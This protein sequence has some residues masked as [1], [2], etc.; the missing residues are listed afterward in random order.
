MAVVAGELRR[1]NYKLHKDITS[2]EADNIINYVLTQLDASASMSILEI[3]TEQWV[4]DCCISVKSKSTLK[5]H[6]KNGEYPTITAYLGVRKPLSS[7]EMSGTGNIRTTNRLKSNHLKLEMDGTGHGDIKLEIVSKLEVLM[8]GTAKL[9]LSGY[10]NDTGIVRLTGVNIFDG[11]RCLMG[12]ASLFVSGIGIAYVVGSA[13]IDIHVSSIGTVYYKGP[14]RQLHHTGV[15]SIKSME[16]WS[17]HLFTSSAN[18]KRWNCLCFTFIIQIIVFFYL[19]KYIIKDDRKS[20]FDFKFFMI[21]YEN[22]YIFDFV[23]YTGHG[24]NYNNFV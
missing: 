17:S 14:I 3:E 4:H 12:K 23:V 15:A 7:I 1:I 2:L 6:L 8:S 20:L 10:V 18:N 5:I 11:K 16:N 13:G 9:T 19:S 21:F 22:G 24:T